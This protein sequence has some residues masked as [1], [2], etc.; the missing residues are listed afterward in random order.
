MAQNCTNCPNDSKFRYKLIHTNG[1]E[2]E[3]VTV[4]LIFASEVEDEVDSNKYSE[5][6]AISFNDGSE[7]LGRVDVE[8][9]VQKSINLH[10]T[11]SKPINYTVIEFRA[12]NGNLLP[13]I[14]AIENVGISLQDRDVEEELDD[15]SVNVSFIV[16]SKGRSSN[17]IMDMIQLFDKNT[18]TALSDP[19]F[20]RFSQ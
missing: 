5:K 4:N 17:A 14:N 15:I 6:I 1:H 11:N 16:T 3:E 10:S 12:L 8:E 13:D 19:R 18:G 9:E 7:N 2:S 20:V